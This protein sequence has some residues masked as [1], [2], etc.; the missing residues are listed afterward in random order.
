[1]CGIAGF[2]GVA[3][4]PAV[5]RNDL[6]TMIATLAH[7]GPD[8]CGFHVDDGIGLAHSRLAIIDPVGGAQPMSN[9]RGSVWISFNGEIFNYIELRKSLQAMGHQFRT[10]SDTEVI[11]HLY[12]RYGD[13]FVE[14]LNGQFAIALWDDE[15]KRLL[16]V[17]DRAGIRPLFYRR[18]GGRLW[19]ASEIKALHAA[20]PGQAR[21]DAQGLVQALTF[22]A[23]V[24]PDTVFADIRNLAPGHLLAIESDGRETL[25]RYWD[26]H[27]PEH[28]APAPFASFD[29]AVGSLRDLLIDAVRLQLR[30]DV[31]VGAYLSGGLDSSAIVALIR[32]YTE[33]P[34]RTFSIA[35]EDA[36]F[37]ESIHQQTMVRHLGTEHT[38]LNC[39]RKDIGEAFPRLIRHAEAPLL[40]TA[41]V[42][43]MLLSARVREAGYKVVL[44]GEGADEVFAGY[45]LFKEAKV[46]RFWARQ[47][48]SRLRPQLLGR[49][50]GYLDQSPVASPAFARA[51]FGQGMEYL[52]RPVFAHMPRW[53]TSQ[54]ALGFLSDEFRASVGDW[55]AA[56]FYEKTLPA[57][58]M[59]W[60]PLSRDQYVEAKSLMGGY[61]LSSQG[62]RAAMANSV[63][64]RFPFLDHRLIEFANRLPPQWKIRGLTE[65]HILRQALADLLPASILQ[66]SKQPYR[67]PDSSSFFDQGKPL[68]YVADLLSG[69][70]IRRAGYFDAKRVGHLF[71]KCRAGRASGFAD[72]QAF[73]GILST[74]LLD[75]QFVR[76][77]SS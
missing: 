46:R 75:D 44:T 67:A 21:I 22:W 76:Q 60:S 74:M 59:R 65:K 58:I 70:R 5:A 26:W 9:P 6:E 54:R 17:R 64:G 13:R 7:R 61:L 18:S 66:R 71:E 10:E 4:S 24:E 20:Q 16:L 50:Y 62:D 43:L 52:D 28:G 55:D 63:E 30:A 57:G 2:L 12:D 39:R 19:F 34:L 33:T 25:T 11:V 8:A 68:D 69:D 45:D 56:A 15:R 38:T 32:H 77:G 51:F 27:F 42:P 40:R 49:L 29:D 37:D 36:E 35:F 23:A 14:H 73:V 72:N 1:M 47:P 53:T 41:P 48:E 3:A 31:P